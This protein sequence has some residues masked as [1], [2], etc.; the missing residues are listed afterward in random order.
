MLSRGWKGSIMA[1]QGGKDA[2]EIQ[3]THERIAELAYQLWEARGCPH[4]SATEDW[5]KAE[6]TL[7]ATQS[8]PKA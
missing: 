2:S 7:R 8:Q 5:L 6:E 3:P 4:G 1:P